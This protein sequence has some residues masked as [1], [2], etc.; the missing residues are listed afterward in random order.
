[1]QRS[2]RSF[3]KNGCPTMVAAS[4]A[5][6]V[7]ASAATKVAATAEA[8][9]QYDNTVCSYCCWG[10]FISLIERILYRGEISSDHL[11]NRMEE[12]KCQNIYGYVIWIN[13]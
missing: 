3:E 8:A 13:V 1:M 4:A 12:H 5:A 10:G 7:A 9:L 11:H 2:E 6:S